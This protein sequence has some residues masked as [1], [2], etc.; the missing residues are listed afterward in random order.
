MRETVR[1]AQPDNPDTAPAPTDRKLPDGQHADHWVLPAAE[2]AKGYV[3]PLRHSYIHV[4]IP[5]PT[6][7]LRDLTAE[8]RESFHDSGYIKFEVYP[9][10]MAPRTGRFWTQEDLDRVGKGCGV[11]TRMPSACAETYAREPGYYG[12]TF[13]C[14]CGKYL[15]VGERGEFVWDGTDERVGT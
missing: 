9:E 8:E 14:G 3:R 1:G 6:Y 4:G 12:S 10:S 7:P 15:P 2:R 5:G 11:E 13:C